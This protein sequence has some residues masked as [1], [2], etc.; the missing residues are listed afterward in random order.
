MS[1]PATAF[2][3]RGAFGPRWVWV[4]AALGLL[5][6]L[7]FLC[8]PVLLGG[9]EPHYALMARSI[10][11][12]HDL[13]LDADYARIHAGS[14]AAGARFA[15]RELAPHVT[16]RAG[17]STF[18]H[19]LGLP[20]LAAPGIYLLSRIVPL[21]AP[22]LLLILGTLVVTFSA[23][24]VGIGLLGRLL[25][26]PRA[27]AVVALVVYF[28]TPL[29]FYSRTFF[30]DPYL[31]AFAVL[32]VGGLVTG[33]PA[34]AGLLLGL[35]LFCKET[36][37][38]LVLAIGTLA[39]SRLGLRRTRPALV[40]FGACAVAWLLRGAWLFGD[41][42]ATTNPF[43][44]GSWRGILGVLF[45]PR[46]GL[47]P[48]APVLLL[49][50]LPEPTPVAPA[51]RATRRGASVFALSILLLTAAWIDWGGGTCYGPRLLLPAIAALAVPLAFV[52][53]RWQ[54]RAVVRWTILVAGAAGFVLGLLAAWDPFRA[55][56][57][58]SVLE[59]VAARPLATAGA[60][61]VAAAAMLRLE[62]FA[63]AGG[64]SQAT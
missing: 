43:V 35:A 28:G 15:G 63:R 61:G 62:R 17:R 11:V 36:A 45:D 14:R 37:V 4:V 58:P 48:F 56:W 5:H 49:A 54:A 46:H 33:R 64:E 12:D 34:R 29:W 31:W 21:A 22:D 3:L 51:E 32:A 52:W 25:G 55:A 47:L 24:L 16:E 7:P 39:C 23:L 60:L 40:A 6:A 9:D 27:G 42:L 10:A 19:G 38:P 57:S 53:R 50:L 2:A 59:L 13:D 1:A 26:D 8:R 20:L 30:A 44:L 18:T 41:P